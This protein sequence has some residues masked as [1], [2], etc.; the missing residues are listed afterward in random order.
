MDMSNSSSALPQKQLVMVNA[1][2][3]C[4]LFFPSLQNSSYQEKSTMLQ[5]KIAHV[6]G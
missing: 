2:V 3:D 6:V 4:Y 1:Q 5:E